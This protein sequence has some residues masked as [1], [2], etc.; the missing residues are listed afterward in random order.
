MNADLL[1]LILDDTG[2]KNDAAIARKLKVAPP[3]ISKWRS[4]RLP[5]GATGI[6]NIHETFGTP[7]RE[8][9][10]LIAVDRPAADGAA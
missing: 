2:L 5:I 4:E 9:R 1:D 3:V 8:I 10:R 7:V 6:L